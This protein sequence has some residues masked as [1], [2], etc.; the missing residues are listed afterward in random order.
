MVLYVIMLD[1]GYIYNHDCYAS[2]DIVAACLLLCSTV[3]D[4]PILGFIKVKDFSMRG[5][6]WPSPV[7][8]MVPYDL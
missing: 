6:Y 7:M 1:L 2:F 4:H 3:L 5:S 8:F